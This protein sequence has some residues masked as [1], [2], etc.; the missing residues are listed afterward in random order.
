MARVPRCVLP[1]GIAHVYARGNRRQAIYVRAGDGF[2][3]LGALDDVTQRF[4]VTCWAYCLM[5]NHYHLVLD[6]PQRQL[7]KA[8]HRLNGSYAHW[9][10]RQYGHWGH[11]FGDRFSAKEVL[12]ER[13]A[14]EVIRYVL[15]NPVRAGLCSHPREWPWSS[16]G[17]TAGLVPRPRLLSLEWMN[18]VPISPAGFA[19]YTDEALVALPETAGV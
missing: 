12:D 8:M 9:F 4:D 15:L 10:N 19:E 2:C 7:S 3:F 18:D 13:Y 16:Y 17:A 6:G 1:D 5:P 14:L 11:V